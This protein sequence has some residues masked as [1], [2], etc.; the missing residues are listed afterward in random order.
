[1]RS[2]DPPFARRPVPASETS[3][4]LRDFALAE[5][6][7]AVGCLA[8][9]GPRVHFG[10]HQARKSIQR[11][12]AVL[13]LGGT[14]LGPG[15]DLVDR[16]LRGIN[17]RLSPLRDAHALVQTLDRLMTKAEDADTAVSLRRARLIASRQRAALAREPE[18]ALAVQQAQSMLVTLRAAATTLDWD[19]LTATGASE[20]MGALAGKANAA[21]KRALSRDDTDEWH[22]WRR[23]MRKLS[24]QRR[25]LAAAG[26]EVPADPSVDKLTTR[27]GAMQ[28]LRLL[29]AL[30][31]KDSPFPKS[32]QDLRRLAER[33]LA[34]HRKRIPSHASRD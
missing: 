9:R 29:S 12:R 30:C 16:E 27:L 18:F 11:A 24:Q 33:L 2:A 1:M 22:R 4:A 28:D 7:R 6:A 15:R 13:A 31:G 20:A 21:R 5:L 10:V 19:A 25:A 32:K 23:C 14:V 3:T 26:L 17:R 34:R 8:M